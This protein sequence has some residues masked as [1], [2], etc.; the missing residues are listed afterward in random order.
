MLYYIS[1][2]ETEEQK[3]QFTEVYMRNR[4]RMY[5]I[6]FGFLRQREEAENAVHDAFMKLANHF[7][8]YERLSEREMDGLCVTIVRNTAI[9]LLDKQKKVT[10]LESEDMEMEWW[11]AGGEGVCLPEEAVEKK[12]QAEMIRRILEG[13]PVIYRDALVLRYYYEFS[14]KE[15]AKMLGISKR[16][17]DMRLYRAKEKLREALDGKSEERSG[18]S[19]G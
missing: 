4:D 1:L 13:L 2:L 5:H 17:A 11:K 15:M 10:A 9:D 7:G 18:E 3:I 12:E 19:A 14:V 16:T 6:A 8:R